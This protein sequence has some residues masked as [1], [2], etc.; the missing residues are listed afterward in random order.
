MFHWWHDGQKYLPLHEKA[1]KNSAWQDE[2]RTLAEVESRYI[3]SVL[4]SVGGNK[5]Q[6]AKIL[7][8]DRK[9]LREEPARHSVP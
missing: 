6:A 7:G 1:D 3:R 9:T 4:E 8:I 2:Y 5:S